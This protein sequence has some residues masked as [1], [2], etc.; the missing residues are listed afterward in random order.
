M[1]ALKDFPP[2]STVHGYFD[3]WSWDGTLDHM[4]DALYVAVREKEGREASSTAAIVDSQSAKPGAKGGRPSI[5][6]AMTRARGP[7]ASSAT[8]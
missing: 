2:K 1:L 8:C 6:S 3:L 7:R 4:R 5:R